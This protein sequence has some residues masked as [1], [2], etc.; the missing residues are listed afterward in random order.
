MD[1]TNQTF[2]A[3]KI[4]CEIEVRIFFKK[5]HEKT[6]TKKLEKKII[7]NIKNI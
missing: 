2:K 1:I 6:R 4:N 7:T 3:V 5:K